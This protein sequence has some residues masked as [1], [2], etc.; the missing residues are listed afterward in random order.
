MP[1]QVSTGVRRFTQDSPHLSRGSHAG[2]LASTD[3]ERGACPRCLSPVSS[4]WRSVWWARG[5]LRRGR[6]R[7]CPQTVQSAGAVPSYRTPSPGASETQASASPLPT[8]PPPPPASWGAR[9]HCPWSGTCS[10][11]AQGPHS[12][13]VPRDPGKVCWRRMDAGT[14]DEGEAR[15]TCPPTEV[16]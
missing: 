1:E 8:P 14:V 3:L 6:C 10:C 12:H 2:S 15:A 9:G 5:T 11:R 13:L 7:P 16:P 4:D